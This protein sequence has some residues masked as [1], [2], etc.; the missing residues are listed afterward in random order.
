MRALFAVLNG[1]CALLSYIYRSSSSAAQSFLC[2]PVSASSAGLNCFL[3]FVAVS[4]ASSDESGDDRRKNGLI[5][6]ADELQADWSADGVIEDAADGSVSLEK[7]NACVLRAIVDRIANHSFPLVAPS[8]QLGE[9]VENASELL[10]WIQKCE[11]VELQSYIDEQWRLF[12]SSAIYDSEESEGLRHAVWAR[13]HYYAHLRH[14]IELQKT[15]KD[16]TFFESL[17]TLLDL[18]SVSESLLSELRSITSVLDPK[19][20]EHVARHIEMSWDRFQATLPDWARSTDSTM[21]KSWFSKACVDVMRSFEWSPHFCFDPELKVSDIA[22]DASK[23][24]AISAFSCVLSCHVPHIEKAVESEFAAEME[25]VPA[26]IREGLGLDLRKKFLL[27]RYVGIVRN[28][29]EHAL[30]E[31]DFTFEPLLPLDEISDEAVHAEATSLYGKVKASHVSHIEQLT[32]SRFSADVSGIDDDI[33][34]SFGEQLKKKWR[35]KH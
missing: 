5:Q 28:I 29:V 30:A 9:S 14:W 10:V 33:L 23:V 31:D 13:Q 16:L 7:E 17:Q 22:D 20:A 18:P 35:K 24:D 1:R 2:I 25:K 32:S 21:K 26:Y 6:D 34:N 19:A 12:R 15:R 3:R 27:R 8:E 4:M 11:A